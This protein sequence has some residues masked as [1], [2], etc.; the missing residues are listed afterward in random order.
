M[1]LE[2]ISFLKEKD[3]SFQSSQIKVTEFKILKNS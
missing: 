3:K 2:E 1:I